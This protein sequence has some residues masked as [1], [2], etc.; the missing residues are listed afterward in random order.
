MTVTLLFRV[1]HRAIVGGAAVSPAAW[2]ID[3]DTIVG[4]RDFVRGYPAT[5]DDGSVN[6]VI[7]FPPERPRSSRR[8]IAMV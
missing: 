6:A 5:N 3:G 8:T 2:P 7:E 4:P 1:P